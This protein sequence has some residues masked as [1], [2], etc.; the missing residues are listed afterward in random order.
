[1]PDV[2]GIERVQRFR[3]SRRE[4]GDREMNVWVPGSVGAAIDEAVESGRFRT[5]QE[6][7]THA[8]EASF[9]R[10]ELKCRDVNQ[11]KQK[12]HEAGNFEGLWRPPRGSAFRNVWQ[13]PYAIPTS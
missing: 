5:R 3:K 4:R 1:M 10:K 9:I 11:A 7:I 12:A 6:A 8:L 13:L 2:K